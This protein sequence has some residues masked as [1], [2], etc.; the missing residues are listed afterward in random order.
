MVV[1]MS[2]D[3]ISV[4]A[5]QSNGRYERQH[6]AMRNN[7]IA[8]TWLGECGHFCFHSDKQF[9]S[10]DMQQAS[11]GIVCACVGGIDVCTFSIK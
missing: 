10:S 5:Q 1:P 11:I 4:K 6:D 2:A 3:G 8:I 7:G 9:L